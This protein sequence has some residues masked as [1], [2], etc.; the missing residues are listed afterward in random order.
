MDV[1]LSL[2]NIH[3][4]KLV[5]T[6]QYAQSKTVDMYGNLKIQRGFCIGGILVSK[7]PSWKCAW[8]KLYTRFFEK[9]RGF[10]GSCHL[11]H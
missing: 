10:L 4:C 8:F 6:Y 9:R 3:R 1:L 11:I 5:A 7:F 2:V